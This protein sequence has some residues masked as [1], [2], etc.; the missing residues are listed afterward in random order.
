MVHVKDVFEPDMKQHEIY[1]ELY[2]NVFRNIYGRLS[3]L[4]TKLNE[5]YR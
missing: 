3:P 5:I 4:Y 1:E 2:E